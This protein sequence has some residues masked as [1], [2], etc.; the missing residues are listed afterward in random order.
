MKGKKGTELSMNVIIITI[1]VILVLVVVAIIFTG[2][3]ANLTNRIKQVFGAQALDLQTS[4][5]ECN[6]YCN[7]F[8]ASGGKITKYRD[9]Y[10]EKEFEIDTNK[11][12]KIDL[13]G[14]CS[15][16]G[17]TCEPIENSDIPCG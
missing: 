12:N 6:G 4:L 8:Q 3:M 15:S 5:V 9:Q 16:L 10:C 11:D 2:G 7:G 17:A 13:V 14:T 1:L